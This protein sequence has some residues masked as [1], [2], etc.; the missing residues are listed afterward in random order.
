MDYRVASDDEENRILIAIGTL[1]RQNM[2]V[3]ILIYSTSCYNVEQVLIIYVRS[4][5]SR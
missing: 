3:Y 1:M 5:P 2:K 4:L